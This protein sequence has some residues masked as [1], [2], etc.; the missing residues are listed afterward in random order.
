MISEDQAVAE[1]LNKFF[2][3]TVPNL[4]ISTNHNYDTDFLV[5]N[6][7]GANALN[8][9]RNHPSIFLIKRKTGQ[10]SSLAPVTYD[11]ILKK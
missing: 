5:T 3:N 9:F 7:Q 8:K 11:D 1:V 10:C 2:I 6:N 4:G